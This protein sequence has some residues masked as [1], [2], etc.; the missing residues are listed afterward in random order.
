M[1]PEILLFVLL[2]HFL[3]VLIKQNIRISKS[4][5]NFH[6]VIHFFVWNY[7]NCCPELCIFFGIPASIAEVAAV[8]PNGSKIFLAKVTPTFINGPA[9]LLKIFQIELI[10]KFQPLLLNAILSF[11]FCLV[12]N[13]NSWVRSFSSNVFKLIFR[14]ALVLLLTAVFSFFS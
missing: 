9:N 5:N 11:V 4:F 1:F 8:I 6:Y 3:S 14:V 2:F 7:W 10:Y 13:S 12:V